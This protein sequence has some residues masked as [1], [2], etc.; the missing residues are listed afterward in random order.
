MTH[1]TSQ[2]LQSFHMDDVTCKA[3]LRAQVHD[4]VQGKPDALC[5][6]TSARPFP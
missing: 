4:K 6:P 5:I 3:T 1:F 2:T